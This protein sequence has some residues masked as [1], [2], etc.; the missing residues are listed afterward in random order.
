VALYALNQEYDRIADRFLQRLLRPSP[1]ALESILR[2]LASYGTDAATIY[3]RVVCP[4]LRRLA[5]LWDGG[6]L[7]PVQVHVAVAEA[8]ESLA[9]LQ[10]RL[11]PAPRSGR[12][13]LVAALAP[14]QHTLPV[15]MAANL[16]EL[17]GWVVAAARGASP[18]LALADHVRRE[19]PD[20]LCL[21]VTVAPDPESFHDEAA[22]VASAA[23]D[24]RS[25]V[26]VGGAALDGLPTPPPADQ[27]VG[28]FPSLVS[29]VREI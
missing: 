12:R 21:S 1:G 8:E 2:T 15:R 6:E 7:S 20:L 14:D 24:S 27:L 10:A 23:A 11:N 29:V 3:D 5:V 19:Q 16:L 9:R 17:E 28:D 26:I 4:G 13:A 18:A 25:T 22:L